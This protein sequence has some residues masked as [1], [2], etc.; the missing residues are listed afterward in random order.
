MTD[1]AAGAPDVDWRTHGVRVVPPDALDDNTPQTPGM[2]RATAVG[3]RTGAV[4]LWAGTVTVEPGARTSAH[5]HGELE[6]VIH[7]LS[8]RARMRWGDRLEFV[9]EAGPGSFVFVP[10][11]VPHREINASVEEPLRCVLAR[12]GAGPV[13]VNLELESVDDPQE[14]RSED[15]LHPPLH[16]PRT[17][18]AG[19]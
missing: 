10:P 13:V 5:T 11:F 19:G 14:V 8:G 4:G 7:V 9:A 6:S 2:A 1:D 15:P 3:A 17:D 18:A 12:T 16:P